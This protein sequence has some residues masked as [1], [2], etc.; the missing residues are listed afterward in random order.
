MGLWYT[1]DSG[2]KLT[3]FS[4]ADYTG[5][6]DT[7]RSTSGGA[8]FL[9]EKLAF[10]RSWFGLRLGGLDQTGVLISKSFAIDFK[11]IDENTL[12]RCIAQLQQVAD[13][14]DAPI[15]TDHHIHSQ[16]KPATLESQQ[17]GYSQ[18]AGPFHSIIVHANANANMLVLGGE[19]MMILAVGILQLVNH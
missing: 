4:D 1:K 15:P 7:F 13:N 18:G 2:F 5:C 16:N 19:G 6:K 17:H 11:Y 3:G 10:S 14:Q 8:Q 12:N 9:G